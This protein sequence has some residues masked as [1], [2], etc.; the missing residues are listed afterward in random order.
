MTWQEI[1]I[2]MGIAWVF[3]DALHPLWESK[4]DRRNSRRDH[5]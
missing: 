3:V 2:I 5:R 4:H 1:V